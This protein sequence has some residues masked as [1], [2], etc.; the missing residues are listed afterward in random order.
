MSASAKG[1]MT[2]RCI[3]VYLAVSLSVTVRCVLRAVAVA[4]GHWQRESIG[5]TCRLRCRFS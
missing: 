5:Y 4:G 2:L 3:A 1:S